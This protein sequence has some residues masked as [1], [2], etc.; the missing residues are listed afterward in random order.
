VRESEERFKNLIHCSLDGIIIIDR[1][2]TIIEWNDAE[3]QMTGV[4]RA[5]AL[6]RALWE[7]QYR[8]APQERRTPAFLEKAREKIFRGLGEAGRLK[9]VLEDEIERAD[10]TR[11]VMQS[12]IFSIE[13]NQEKF[14]CGICRDVTDQ[15]RAEAVLLERMRTVD[16]ELRDQASQLQRL[17]VEI[18][19]AE[20]E[21]R[22]RISDVLHG[23]LQQRLAAAKLQMQLL[24]RR[25]ADDAAL[26][27]M[28]ERVDLMLKDAIEQSR[29]LSHA[30]SPPGLT[31]GNLLQTLDWLAEE[32]KVQHGLTVQL[33]RPETLELR[34]DLL[35]RLLYRAAQEL[36]FNIVKHAA[37]KEAG[38]QIR[39]YRGWICLA[40]SD[41]G[42]GFD[43]VALQNAP[44]YG[45]LRVQ[46]RV[47]LLGG[48]MRV[49][50][51]PGKGSRF[52]LVLPTH[53]GL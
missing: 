21:E 50:S 43:P 19:Q 25:V 44:V 42:C 49:K 20:D 12:I 9:R 48:R 26:R 28:A 27:E 4:P 32:M 37:V 3:A 18:T 7:I 47:K 53:K 33:R 1:H 11:R 30:L 23:D 8:L 5:E 10:G 38:L 24:S 35:T 2:G 16:R 14:A 13:S 46:E 22:R 45:L 40:V 39:Q 36:L 34:S 6:G 17:S 15:K 52:L 31:G 51:T 41:E 29:S